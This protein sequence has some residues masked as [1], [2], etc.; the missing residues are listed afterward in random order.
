ML[1]IPKVNLY[2]FLWF[3]FLLFILSLPW[4]WSSVSLWNSLQ[5]LPNQSLWPP[6]LTCYKLPSSFL[7][8]DS[9]VS[10]SLQ[11]S[12][13]F[14]I[15]CK[16]FTLEL[17]V[18]QKLLPAYITSCSTIALSFSHTSLPC[19]LYPWWNFTPLCSCSCCSSCPK[20]P[21]SLSVPWE[22]LPSFSVYLNHLLLCE[23]T[24][25]WDPVP[26]SSSPYSMQQ[27]DHLPSLYFQGTSQ[28]FL[29]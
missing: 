21:S 3:C 2:S 26:H 1:A 24:M 7:P 6:V 15:V 27:N 12:Q 10:T 20:C 19:F 14:P 4:F 5:Y 8:D 23:V 22:I 25:F 29:F 28:I 13:W 16:V 17:K 18:L 9:L 11:S